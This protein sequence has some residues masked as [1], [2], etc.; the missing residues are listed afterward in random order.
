[1]PESDDQK[2]GNKANETQLD[3]ETYLNTFLLHPLVSPVIGIILGVIFGFG[4]KNWLSGLAA[5][6]LASIA[7]FQ[8]QETIKAKRS[9]STIEIKSIGNINAIKDEAV[10]ILGNIQLGAGF[11]QLYN[12]ARR[13]PDKH[14]LFYKKVMQ[15]ISA[16]GGAIVVK[17]EQQTYLKHLKGI[18][19][20]SDDSVLATLRGG[21]DKPQYTLDW[22]LQTGGNP[23]KQQRLNWLTSVRDADISLKIRLLLFPEDDIRTF[24]LS[25]NNRMELLNAM[26]YRK[27]GGQAGE[28]YQVDPQRLFDILCVSLGNEESRVVYDD[29]A[30]FDQQIVL[31]HNGAAALT[32][33][34]KEQMSIYLEVFNT[35]NSHCELF[36]KITLSHYG[37][38]TW[39]EWDNENINKGSS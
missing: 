31:K 11:R 8:S 16:R 24:L 28:I 18:L 4:C 3:T 6:T 37:D 23:S 5:G 12:L 22:F 27:D 35:L 21:R 29:F 33:S 14:F 9:I 25:K 10:R 36:R 1:M 30:V 26:L 32:M 17:A 39:E 15:G 34:I 13:L 2:N 19:D 20:H 38:M 7:A